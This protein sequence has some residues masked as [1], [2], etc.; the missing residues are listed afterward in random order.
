MKKYSKF[1][2]LIGLNYVDY[3]EI[4]L[5]NRISIIEK[6][7]QFLINN[8]GFC[9]EN[10]LILVE[11]K[12]EDILITLNTIIGSSSF[13]TEFW[14]YYSG[15]GNG[16][17]KNDIWSCSESGVMTCTSEFC[18]KLGVIDN[19]TKQMMSS[20]FMEITQEEL[21]P[22]LTQSCCKTICIMDMC[23]FGTEMVLKWGADVNNRVKIITF[24]ES[25]SYNTN[26]TTLLK[27]MLQSYLQIVN[28][29]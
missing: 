4:A 27:S 2:L 5:T 16:I 9:E 19:M 10:I 29:P 8:H 7:K 25:D 3:P 13:L 26:K 28:D 18:S 24:C 6:T 15:Y 17:M 21:N 23:H 20:D 14:I 11:P 1:A 22:I 12:R